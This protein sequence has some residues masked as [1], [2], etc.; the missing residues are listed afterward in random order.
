MLTQE[1]F[2][3]LRTYIPPSDMVKNVFDE[4]HPE[5]DFE[6]WGDAVEHMIAES[7]KGDKRMLFSIMELVYMNA[8]N[9]GMLEAS[10]LE[11]DDV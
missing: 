6:D 5:L 7:L 1:Q 9:E 8:H 3:D 2:A 11:E 10:A 4:T